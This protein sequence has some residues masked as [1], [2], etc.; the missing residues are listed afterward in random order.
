MHVGQ[1][2]GST[3][4]CLA[5]HASLMRDN[6]VIVIVYSIALTANERLSLLFYPLVCV[7]AAIR[8][9][10]KTLYA[11]L[12]NLL[13]VLHALIMALP[14]I[15]HFRYWSEIRSFQLVQEMVEVVGAFYELRGVGLHCKL[16]L[17]DH[18]FEEKINHN[19]V[20]IV[21][22]AIFDSENFDL[23]LFKNVP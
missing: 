17:A 12:L 3:V 9:A 8:L 22:K 18:F 1:P 6:I 16:Y 10:F 14:N 5:A 11:L 19:I 20:I 21:I 7:L 23:S 13:V 2:A 15:A 4:D